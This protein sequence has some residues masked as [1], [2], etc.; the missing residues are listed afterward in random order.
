LSYSFNGSLEITAIRII[1]LDHLNDFVY[2]K[3]REE[4][5]LNLVISQVVRVE[6]KLWSFGPSLLVSS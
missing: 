2:F 3:A 1:I 5:I 4:E 6:L